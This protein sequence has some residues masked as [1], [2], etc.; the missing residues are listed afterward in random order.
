M[1]NRA[2][3][4]LGQLRAQGVDVSGLSVDSR[5]LRRGEVFLAYPGQNQ[6]GR[7]HIAGAIAA[8][9]AAILWER[10]GFD[11]SEGWRVPNQPVDGLRN[12]AGHMAH[13]VYGQPSEKLWVMG[14]TGTNGKTSCS[15]WLAEGCGACG[16]RTAVI[17]TL[18]IGLPG[19]MVPSPN[20]TPEAVAVHRSLGQLLADGAQGAVVEVSSIALDQERVNGVRFGVALFTNLSRDHLDY[21]GDMERYA[22][23]KQALFHSPGLKHAVVNMDDVQGV[24]I[25][26]MLAGSGVSRT[27]YSCFDGTARRAGLEQYVEAH[28]VVTS[29]LGIAFTAKSSWGD[30]RIE[31]RLLGRFNIANLLGVLATMLVSGVPLAKAGGALARL[32]PVAGRLERMGGGKQPLVVVDYAHTP[33]A[34]DKVALVLSELAGA[35]SGRLCVVFGCGGDRDRGKRPLM[36]TAASRYADRVLVTADNPRGEDPVAI[37]SEIEQGVSVDHDVII[38]RRAAI[39]AAVAWARPGDVVLIAGKGHETYQEIGG[40]R[41][42]FSDVQEARLALERWA[43]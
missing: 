11:W 36:G 30:A 29:A 1:R 20:T 25:A 2:I 31:S 16:A 28:D 23:A 27:G 24:S 34:L 21:H 33:D 4:I 14:V 38:D 22:K 42:P 40:T 43:P 8:G 12:L 37:A 18:G 39:A 5:S 10:A 26:R 35:Q 6:D 32:V 15:H 3:E 41:L 19:A 9:A 7:G 13:E 17:G